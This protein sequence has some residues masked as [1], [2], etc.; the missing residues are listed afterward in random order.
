MSSYAST[1]PHRPRGAF[2]PWVIGSLVA[3]GIGLAVVEE[4][5]AAMV[6]LGIGLMLLTLLIVSAWSSLPAFLGFFLWLHMEDLVRLVYDNFAVFF[7]KDVL[8]AALLLGFWLDLRRGGHRIKNPLGLPLLAFGVMAVIQCFNPNVPGLAIPLV[9]IHA[10]LLYVALLF[11]GMA[12]FDSD[13]KVTHFLLFLVVAVA[14]ESVIALLQYFRDP[15][16][17]YATMNL[18]P[19]AEVIG[20]RSYTTGGFVKTGSIF[21]NA[22]RFSQFMV[23]VSILVLGAQFVLAKS[24]WMGMLWYVSI[25]AVFAGGIVLQSSRAVFYLFCLAAIGILFL[26]GRSVARRLN[27]VVLAG[28]FFVVLKWGV[29]DIDPRLAQFYL[30]S[31]SLNTSFDE[32]DAIGGR[33]RRGLLQM[34]SSIAEAG[35]LGHGTGT[36]SQGTHHFGYGAPKENGYA[37]LIWEFGLLGPLLWI[38][39]MATLLWKGIG[40][41][42]RVSRGPY[43]R[44]AFSVV[45]LIGFAFVLQYVGLQYLENY[46]V[47]THFW[48]FVGLLFA[49]PELDRR[50][51]SGSEPR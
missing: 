24:R 13:E 15:G 16:W 6:V 11:I 18:N 40:V 5:L 36:A 12:Y 2:L 27:A 47:I 10:K 30:S 3:V 28:M 35:W 9:G 7:V 19:D 31:S 38:W 21:N 45:V 44:L 42:R 22:G 51:R 33:V 50:A 1:M 34:E 32:Y 14:V 29:T 4:R 46:L 26:E 20:M 48:A 8:L 37:A 43:G 17:W 41:Y 39:M 49:L 25:I 23:V